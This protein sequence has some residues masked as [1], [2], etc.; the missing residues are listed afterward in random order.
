MQDITS[1]D[2]RAAA[3]RALRLDLERRG[4]QRTVLGVLRED[5][6]ETV[7]GDGYYAYL[8]AVFDTKDEAV[9]FAADNK[10]H[11]VTW[12]IRQYDL[13]LVDGEPVVIA[14]REPIQLYPCAPSNSDFVPTS[15]QEPINI[16]TLIDSWGLGQPGMAR[17]L[18]D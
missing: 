7:F 12:H 14:P 9:A 15:D 10:E 2:I 8:S 6:Y 5:T 17:V 1:A 13:R 4:G 18:G 11:S 3:R 16:D